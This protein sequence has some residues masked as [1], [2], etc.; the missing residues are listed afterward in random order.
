MTG[1]CLVATCIV[2]PTFVLLKFKLYFYCLCLYAYSI[3][4]EE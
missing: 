2:T 3:L 1:A 4:F